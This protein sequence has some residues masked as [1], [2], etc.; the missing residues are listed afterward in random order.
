LNR[1][2]TREN[3]WLILLAVFVAHGALVLLATRATRQMMSA[4]FSAADSLL[5]LLLPQGVPNGPNSLEVR[6]GVEFRRSRAPRHEPEPERTIPNDAISLP[7]TSRPPP[8]ID[9]ARE[10]EA[11]VQHSLAEQDKGRSYRNLSRLSAAQL[12]WIRRNHMVP[13]PPSFQW[14]HRR[15]DNGNPLGVIWIGQHCALVWLIPFCRIGHIEANGE[16]LEHM[17]DPKEP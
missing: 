6:R 5:L 1:S 12:D 2:G 8:P 11:A 13:M 15:R 3:R 16:L 17:R 9:W 7:D 4:P 10:A 14:D